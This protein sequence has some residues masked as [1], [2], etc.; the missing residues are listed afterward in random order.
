MEYEISDHPVPV[1]PAPIAQ[2]EVTRPLP[3]H[4]E[5]KAIAIPEEEPAL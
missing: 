1:H 4:K 5:R 3:P 2:H